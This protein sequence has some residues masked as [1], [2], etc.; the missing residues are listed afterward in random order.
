M[1]SSWRIHHQ[2]HYQAKRVVT[3][4]Q[5]K[6]EA[7]LKKGQ[8]SLERKDT[9]IRGIDTVSSLAEVRHFPSQSASL[10]IEWKEQSWAGTGL[11]QSF[12]AKG[13]IITALGLWAIVPCYNY[14]TW[15]LQC[16]GSHRQPVN[17]GCVYAPVKLT[18][19]NRKPI[20]F[21]PW[22]LVAKTC[23]NSS[24]SK[25]VFFQKKFKEIWEN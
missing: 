21:G 8:G 20:S 1:I 6:T 12:S 22:V 23:S 11:C 9:R 19:T 24:N 15:I 17:D 18:Y 4:R 2:S 13:Q 16:K 7:E 3:G 10:S 5:R 25:N 14:S